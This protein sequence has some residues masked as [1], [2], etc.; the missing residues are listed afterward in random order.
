MIEFLRQMTALDVLFIL[1]WLAVLSY[2]VV[3]GI[4]R[5]I[6]FIGCI[7]SGMVVGSFLAGPVSQWTGAFSGVGAARALPLTYVFVVV[8]VAAVVFLASQSVY[9]ET[10]LGFAQAADRVGGLVLGF[11]A[12]LLVVIQ[13]AAMLLVVTHDP[14]IVLEG[15]RANIRLQLESTPFLPLLADTFPI[16]ASA[17]RNLV[18]SA[19]EAACEACAPFFAG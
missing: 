14:W 15:A 7:F 18:P 5:Q 6:L 3:T 9:P 4:I 12:G 13:L 2:G 16:V 8:L 19:L 10:R 1:L 11:M 17:V